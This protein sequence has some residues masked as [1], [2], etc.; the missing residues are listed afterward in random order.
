[1]C[2]S[3]FC[4]VCINCHSQWS[5]TECMDS[6]GTSTPSLDSTDHH[7]AAAREALFPSFIT[8]SLL[9]QSLASLPFRHPYFFLIYCVISQPEPEHFYEVFFFMPFLHLFGL[10]IEGGREWKEQEKCIESSWRAGHEFI[11]SVLAPIRLLLGVSR[12]LDLCDFTASP[13]ILQHFCHFTKP[14]NPPLHPS[15]LPPRPHL[16]GSFFISISLP[17][18]IISQ[19]IL[20]NV[21]IPS[22]SGSYP[23]G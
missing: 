23:R 4:R 22:A 20:L 11:S 17:F 9:Y 15:T 16:A 14:P 6:C 19:L 2:A 21:S 5:S 12:S 18:V 3:S 7:A 1:M 8:L 10:S 13:L